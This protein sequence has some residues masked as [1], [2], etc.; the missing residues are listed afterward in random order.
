MT[1]IAIIDNDQ[2]SL[3]VLQLLIERQGHSVQSFSS[4]KDFLAAFK[5]GRFKVILM[6]L[7]MPDMDGYELLDRVRT[8][9]PAIPVIAV[10]ARA[11]QSDRDRAQSAGFSDFVTKPFTD[12]P[13]FFDIVLKHLRR[14]SN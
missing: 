3:D 5:P 10:T 1:T 7:G 12:M 4:G 13:T 9:E 8:Q 6:D 11:Q 2:D 14:N